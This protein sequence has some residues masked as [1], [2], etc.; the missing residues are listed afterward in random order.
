MRTFPATLL[1]VMGCSITALAQEATPK[2]FQVCQGTYALCTF[3]QCG[4]AQ[5]K[6]QQTSACSCNVWQGYSVGRECE[7][8][9]IVNGQTVI[10]SRYYPIPGYGTCSNSKAWAMCLDKKCVVDSN[11]KTKASCTC[12]VE[13]QGKQQDYLVTYGSACPAG[14]ISSATV[15]DLNSITDFLKTKDEIPVQDFIISPKK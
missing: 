7:K 4:P 10:R 15:L 11:D 1:I 9:K 2:P 3:S 12:S 6:G 13:G 14:I 8:S 5:G